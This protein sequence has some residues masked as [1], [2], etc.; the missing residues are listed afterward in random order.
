MD[1][2]ELGKA[3]EL[4][5]RTGDEALFVKTGDDT[6]PVVT[7]S[8]K[9]P[10]HPAIGH[11]LRFFA[12]DH[13]PAANKDLHRSFAKLAEEIAYAGPDS[14][15]TTVALRALLVAKDAAIRAVE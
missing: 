4:F 9:Q 3:R 12:F 15:E 6:F 7:M 13:L 14:Q 2:T 1:V 11:V 8:M 10:H 5:V